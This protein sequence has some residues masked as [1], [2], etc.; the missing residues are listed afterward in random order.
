[1]ASRAPSRIAS[2]ATPIPFSNEGCI[3]DRMWI[4]G[5]FS[6][7]FL[8]QTGACGK[9]RVHGAA[10]GVTLGSHRPRPGRR[11]PATEAEGDA[12]RGAARAGRR[13]GQGRGAVH[14][15]VM[16]RAARGPGSAPPSRRLREFAPPLHGATPGRASRPGHA[17]PRSGPEA[18]FPPCPRPVCRAAQARSRGPAGPPGFR[19]RARPSRGDCAPTCRRTRTRSR[20]DVPRTRGHLLGHRTKCVLRGTIMRF[21]C[22]AAETGA[23]AHPEAERSRIHGRSAWHLRLRHPRSWR[24]WPRSLRRP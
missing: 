10:L 24:T 14:G 15:R 21:G 16:P 17:P 3:L 1:M 12:P 2:S 20:S 5:T 23:S 8:E 22:G 9:R 11:V 4:R 7:P 18:A 13:S 6:G 19:P